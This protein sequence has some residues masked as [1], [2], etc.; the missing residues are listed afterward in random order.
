MFCR[1]VVCL[2]QQPR[3]GK[4]RRRLQTRCIAMVLR[5]NGFWRCFLLEGERRRHVA[6]LG[7]WLRL[8][9]MAAWQQLIP[10]WGI[11]EEV[12]FGV[13]VLG[14]PTGLPFWMGKGLEKRDFRGFAQSMPWCSGHTE[15]WWGLHRLAVE[16]WVLNCMSN[17]YVSSKMLP[18]SL[19]RGWLGK[20]RASYR[21]KYSCDDRYR[22]ELNGW[23]W[24]GIA[25]VCRDIRFLGSS[26]VPLLVAEIGCTHVR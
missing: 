21:T 22:T 5:L 18:S 2:Q 11:V 9:I 3:Q 17:G 12:G 14:F 8:W 24:D 13:W 7:E 19:P 16:S 15:F 25:M 23:Q 4:G 20:F 10:G 1:V 26:S 6:R